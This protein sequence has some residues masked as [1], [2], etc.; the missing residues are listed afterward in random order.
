MLFRSTPLSAFRP[1]VQ[2]ILTQ[3]D[4]SVRAD[5]TQ[6]GDN[7]DPNLPFSHFAHNEMFDANLMFDEPFVS[8]FSYDKAEFMAAYLRDCDQ[9][10]GWDPFVIFAEDTG[11]SF[12][13]ELGLERSKGGLASVLSRISLAGEDVRFAAFMAL[14][15]WSN[16]SHQVVDDL[17][18][19][20]LI[21]MLHVGI[22]TR[23]VTMDPVTNP[24]PSILL[25]KAP[26][27]DLFDRVVGNEGLEFD[28][29]AYRVA[30][31]QVIDGQPLPIT[32]NNL[33]PHLLYDPVVYM[34]AQGLSTSNVIR[35]IK[36]AFDLLVERL[37]PEPSQKQILFD[38]MLYNIFSLYPDRLATLSIGA[39]LR[40]QFG[41]HPGLRDA[42]SLTAL[43]R[44]LAGPLGA[45][46]N[47]LAM[48]VPDGLHVQ[49]LKNEG[50][51]TLL[52]I[53]DSHLSRTP[54]VSSVTLL[55]HT[56][57]LATLDYLLARGRMANETIHYA[58]K[59]M[60]PLASQMTHQAQWELF[61]GEL[62]FWIQRD[63]V[64]DKAL[65]IAVK[66]VKDQPH[67][68]QNLGEYMV[69]LLDKGVPTERVT[70]CAQAMGVLDAQLLKKPGIGKHHVFHEALMGQDLGL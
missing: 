40:F 43:T 57:D 35:R 18:P 64:D 26:V 60:A 24:A 1:E 14:V 67:L 68:L 46:A 4:Q 44:I 47:D 70:R 13:T 52:G 53:V 58:L 25:R 27:T 31:S 21:G 11:N 19:G 54:V 45:F 3:L 59:S 20:K 36:P 23:F 34:C 6:A 66:M 7:V 29:M 61:K 48:D 37:D 32:L 30:L 56:E 17:D 62:D 15:E 10:N 65:H 63:R 5:M 28:E 55:E 39:D 41:D 12:S 8:L 9:A 38:Q 42:Q 16:S 51:H 50:I 69:L 22:A 33:V 49:R 2:A